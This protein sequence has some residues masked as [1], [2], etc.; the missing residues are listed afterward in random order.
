MTTGPT[1]AYRAATVTATDAVHKVVL[2][3][4][5]IIADLRRA[6]SDFKRNDIE[7]RTKEIDHSLAVVGQLQG[8]LDMDAGGDVALN[9]NRF[10]DLLRASL[11]EA[12]VKAQPQILERQM[13]HLVMLREAWVEV[14]HAEAA[15]K[16]QLSA[17][18]AKTPPV[19]ADTVRADWKA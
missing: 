10:Y 8:S 15:A 3:Y 1:I 9:L 12:Q 7:G 5:Q 19:S 14:E 17:A 13:A 16:A 18:S 6:L 2:L 11:L 4:E